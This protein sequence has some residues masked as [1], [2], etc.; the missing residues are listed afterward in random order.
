MRAYNANLS[1]ASLLKVTITDDEVSPDKRETVGMTGTRPL[2]Q[3]I[4]WNIFDHRFR[5]LAPREQC[6]HESGLIGITEL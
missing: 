3:V 4:L 5:M 1:E 6:S 2:S